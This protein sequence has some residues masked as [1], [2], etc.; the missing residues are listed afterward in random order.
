MVVGVIQLKDQKGGG[1][2]SSGKKKH[3]GYTQFREVKFPD[4]RTVSKHE[5]TH[6]RGSQ[7]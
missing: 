7:I 1:N 2:V 5:A 3:T 6:P 4:T